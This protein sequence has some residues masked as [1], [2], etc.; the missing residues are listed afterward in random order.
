VP[1]LSLRIS[2]S[3]RRLKWMMRRSRLLMGLKWNGRRVRFTLSAAVMA[4]SR[5]SS[6]R[7]VR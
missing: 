3:F 4:L 5:S 7:K 6:I 2:V 1:V